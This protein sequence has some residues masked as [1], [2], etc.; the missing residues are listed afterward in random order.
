MQRADPSPPRTAA[1][2]SIS[3]RQQWV[4]AAALICSEQQ[5]VPGQAPM[6]HRGEVLAYGA[7]CCPRGRRPSARSAAAHAANRRTMG[8]RRCSSAARPRMTATLAVF[9]CM[10]HALTHSTCHAACCTAPPPR[11]AGKTAA[12][13]AAA[14]LSPTP[15][16]APPSA[17]RPTSSPRGPSTAP[18]A[19]RMH[20]RAASLPHST[21]RSSRTPE[22]DTCHMS[23]HTT[24]AVFVCALE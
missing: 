6:G 20:P 3:T 4:G 17:P 1:G 21:L 8:R 10:W 18:A 12:G 19:A 7:A 5:R 16:L 22:R 15:L 24:W 23:A 9:V 11:A 14:A 13:Q 2:R